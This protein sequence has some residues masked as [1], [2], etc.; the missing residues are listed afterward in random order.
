LP[1]ERS[2]PGP[3][4][5]VT[6]LFRSHG[7]FNSTIRWIPG[8]WCTPE[9]LDC[10][11]YFA[12]FGKFL[13]NQ[14][15]TIL[16]GIEAIRLGDWLFSVFAENDEVFARPTGCTK[17]FTG[18]RIPRES[19]AD[20]L[21]PTRYDPATLVVVAAPRQI[22]REWRLVVAKGLVIAAS[23]YA[24]GGERLIGA[25]CPNEVHEF[26]ERMLTEVKWQPDPVFMVDVCESDGQLWL[27]ELNGF[28][29]S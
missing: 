23:Q 21:S 22:G 14:R 11:T 2:T 9:N 4:R 16:P 25:G 19:F 13:L 29:C 15:Y 3:A 28:S 12:H 27:V 17:L 24:R 10:S 7:R 1:A 20:A 8:A 6:A 18:R 26:V 5:S